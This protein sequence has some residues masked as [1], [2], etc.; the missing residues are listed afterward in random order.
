M[1]AIEL[2]DKQTD[3]IAL[4]LFLNEAAWVRHCKLYRLN[5][6]DGKSVA[7]DSPLE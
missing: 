6:A 5:S 3:L 4:V 7:I 1:S 2:V